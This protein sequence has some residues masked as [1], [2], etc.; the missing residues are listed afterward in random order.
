VQSVVGGAYSAIKDGKLY[1][2]DFKANTMYVYEKDPSSGKW[3]Q[4]GDPVKTPDECQ[5]VLVRDEGY[6]FSSSYG[7]DNGSSL[8]IQNRDDETD[9]SDPYVLPNMSQGVVEV[10]GELGVTYESGAEKFDPAALDWLWGS[11][12]MTASGPT[13]S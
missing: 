11:P 1:L 8:I 6:V 4:A 3:V 5:G 2:G 13:R 7:R 10:N 9:R 12:T